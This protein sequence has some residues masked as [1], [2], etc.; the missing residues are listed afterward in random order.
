MK[1]SGITL[2]FVLC[3]NYLYTQNLVQNPNFETY[4][5]CPTGASEVIK[6]IPWRDPTGTSSDYFNACAS[7]Y[8]NVPNCGGQ[9]LFISKQNLE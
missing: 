9:V 6:A 1:K 7:G 3:I 5:T 8:A 4:S 2:F